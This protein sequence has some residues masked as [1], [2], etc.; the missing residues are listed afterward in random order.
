MKSEIVRLAVEA[1]R[2]QV[3]NKERI[4]SL[5]KQLDLPDLSEAKLLEL[6]EAAR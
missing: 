1:Y 3:I 5:A 4:G 2:R 6:A